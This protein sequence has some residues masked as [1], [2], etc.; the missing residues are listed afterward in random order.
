MK[1]QKGVVAV[2]LL[3]IMF[4]IGFS[5]QEQMLDDAG[6][7]EPAKEACNNK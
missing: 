5:A 2:A 3:A 6:G 4:V 7:C 1:K